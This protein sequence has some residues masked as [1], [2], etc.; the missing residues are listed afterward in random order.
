MRRTSERGEGKM[1]TFIMFGL[2]IAMGLA[3]WNVIPVY[4][5]HYDFTDKVEEICRTPV[6][7]ARTKEAIK[8]MLVKEVRERRLG[9]WIGPDSFEIS[10]TTRSR[11]I[12]LRYERKAKVLPGWEK[13][14]K[15]EYTA[16]QPLL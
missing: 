11:L 9:Q 5:A 10:T 2:L 7:K 8:A 15:F 6:Y 12:Q 14:F 13:V 4:Y 1:G 16:E 3:A